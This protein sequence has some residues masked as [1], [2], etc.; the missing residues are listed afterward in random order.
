MHI[1]NL[2]AYSQCENYIHFRHYDEEDYKV[3]HKSRLRTLYF[4]L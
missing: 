3:L 1:Q 2:V 4:S